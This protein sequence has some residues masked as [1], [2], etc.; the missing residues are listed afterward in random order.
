MLD[1]GT[2]E[3]REIGRGMA[4]FARSIAGG[5]VRRRAGRR[6]L[7]RRRRDVRKRQS[8]T[9]TLGAVVRDSGVIHRVH[10]VIIRVGM[11]KRA[12]AGVRCRKRNVIGRDSQCAGKGRRREMAI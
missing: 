5:N 6:L 11:T 8:R 1:G 12:I 4:Q 2:G 3:S 7:E 9:M 10:A